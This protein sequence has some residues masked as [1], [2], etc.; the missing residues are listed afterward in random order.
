MESVFLG[1]L[2]GVGL[3]VAGFLESALSW[4]PPSEFRAGPP[5]GSRLV[6][7]PAGRRRPRV[8]GARRL[9][10]PIIFSKGQRESAR[11]PVVIYSDNI[12]IALGRPCY[13]LDSELVSTTTTSS[14]VILTIASMELCGIESTTIL[15]NFVTFRWR[16]LW[17]STI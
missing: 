8:L 9:D 6:R 3:F 13:F 7:Q 16:N 1:R 11:R 17:Q 4:L 15:E 2:L 14:S 5:S 10:R 12:N